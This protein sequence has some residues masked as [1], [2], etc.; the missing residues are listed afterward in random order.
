MRYNVTQMKKYIL[1]QGGYVHNCP[2]RF[3]KILQ[4]IWCQNDRIVSSILQFS[5]FL[6]PL[7][8]LIKNSQTTTR[9]KM[10]FICLFSRFMIAL[11]CTFFF[12][13]LYPST[14]LC[15]RIITATCTHTKVMVVINVLEVIYNKTWE[16]WVTLSLPGQPALDIWPRCWPRM[17]KFD[18]S[19][20]STLSQHLC[21]ISSAAWSWLNE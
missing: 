7:P 21:W 17:L 9:L 6:S 12:I 10:F 20:L 16:N 1:W 5:S 11:P 2:I 4:N 8:G 3:S 19:T 14:N 18:S 15:S 13:S